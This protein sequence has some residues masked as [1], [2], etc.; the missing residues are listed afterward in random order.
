[1]QDI[2]HFHPW[3]IE[4]S[5]FSSVLA[6]K[7]KSHL[8]CRTVYL[9]VAFQYVSQQELYEW[10]MTENEHLLLKVF[11]KYW[12]LWHEENKTK[13]R[14]TNHLPT[15]MFF[16]LKWSDLEKW[17]DMD[18]PPLLGINAEREMLCAI[19]H[20]RVKN[21][22]PYLSIFWCRQLALNFTHGDYW[23][24]LWVPDRRRSSRLRNRCAAEV[25]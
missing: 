3:L 8:F 11:W 25:L 4:V 1:M 2:T 6:R 21:E 20:Y 9:F 5:E 24:T 10:N 17:R 16:S 7:W 22:N 12:F 23:Q 19:F 14:L 13:R 18:L 15:K